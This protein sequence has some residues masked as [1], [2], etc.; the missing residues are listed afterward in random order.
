MEHTTVPELQPN[1]TP[2]SLSSYPPAAAAYFP[3]SYPPHYQLYFQN[4]NP[5]SADPQSSAGTQEFH[6][7]SGAEPGLNPP[8]VTSYAP[9]TSDSVS[10]LT[11]EAHAN[12]SYAH[13]PVADS[14]SGYYYDPNAQNWAAREAVMQFGMDPAGYG[15]AIPVASTG[16]EQLATSNTNTAWWT[17]TTTQPQVNGARKK[18]KKLKIKVVQSAYCEVCKIDCTSKDVLDQHKLGKK[19]KKNL[20]KL[21]EA[22]RPPPQVPVL[23]NTSSNPV[24]GPQPQPEGDNSKSGGG[25]KKK[26]KATQT[27]AD[28]ENKKK[29]VLEGGAAAAA[30]KICTICNVVCNSETVFNY[31][32][33]GQKHAAMLKKQAS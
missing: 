3:A 14:S 9:A 27:P 13:N 15:A 11:H 17:N 12:Y 16:S 6:G 23:P 24:I 1:P 21:K 22:L 5:P 31:H 29:K 19:H 25:S 30:V 28:L 10:H 4:P 26:R 7:G 8:G 20:E 32:L 18:P 33:A 2:A